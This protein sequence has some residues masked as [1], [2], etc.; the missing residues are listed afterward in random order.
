MAITWASGMDWDE[1]HRGPA[2]RG[3]AAH[4]HVEFSQLPLKHS[5]VRCEG[6]WANICREEREDQMGLTPRC[7]NSVDWAGTERNRGLDL[8]DP[9]RVGR[10]EGAA[11]R[12][13]SGR[14]YSQ[15]K[16]LTRASSLKHTH[17]SCSLTSKKQTTQSKSRQ[18][19]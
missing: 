13:R 19:I 17:S 7:K 10:G 8:R 5:W 12:I 3:G 18:K 6:H 15:M 2:A 14:K 9:H 4:L 1:G 16:Q 11:A